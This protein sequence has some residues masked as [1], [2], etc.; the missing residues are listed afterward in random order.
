MKKIK[1]GALLICALCAAALCLLPLLIKTNEKAPEETGA[2]ETASRQ[3]QPPRKTEETPAISG[4][5]SSHVSLPTQKVGGE[6]LLSFPCAVSEYDLV[7]EK[8]DSYRG[9]FVEDGTNGQTSSVAMLLV[10]NKGGLPLE[11]TEIQILCGDETL[12]FV[13]SALPAGESL[14]VQEKTGKA[15]PAAKPNSGEATV[16]TRAAFEMHEKSISVKDN[17]DSSLTLTNLTEEKL[18]SVRVFYKYYKEGVYVG[19]IAFS[20]H[21]TDLEAGK[22]V[23]VKPAHFISGECRVVMVQ[24]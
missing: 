6:E 14:L 13:I 17:G 8:L 12:K 3:D 20:L 7:L 16:I 23:T 10:K 1:W 15:L 24:I 18:S 5:A 21:V 22:S 4:E 19:G 2:G 9:I 11:Y